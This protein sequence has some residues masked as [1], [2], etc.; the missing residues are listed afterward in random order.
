MNSASKAKTDEQQIREMVARWAQAVRERDME[1]AI[2]KHGE[3]MV[4]FDVPP[5]FA[6]RGI[7][8]YKA[9][10]VPFFEWMGDSGGFE[11]DQLEVTA[12]QDVAFCHGRVR[13]KGWREKDRQGL[14]IRLTVCLR[15]IDG[16]WIVM[17]EHH[18][19]PSAD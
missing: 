2:A 1:G 15:K 14:N 17:H 8:E 16:E 18:S 6:L 12:G 10:W 13:C 19:E 9:S 5:P 4:M 11:V 7:E 3:E